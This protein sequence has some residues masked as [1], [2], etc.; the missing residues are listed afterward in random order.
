MALQGWTLQLIQAKKLHKGGAHT[1]RTAPKWLISSENLDQYLS[2]QIHKQNIFVTNHPFTPR[3]EKVLILCDLFMH[4]MK[5][6]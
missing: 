6:K 3:Y 2:K 5:L 1:Q 4:P